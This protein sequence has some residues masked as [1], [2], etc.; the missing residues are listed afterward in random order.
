[1]MRFG[2]ATLQLSCKSPDHAGRPLA[3]D[4]FTAP[5]KSTLNANQRSLLVINSRMR[6]QTVRLMLQDFILAKHSRTGN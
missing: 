2:S 6:G 3:M 5:E 1:M 4:R